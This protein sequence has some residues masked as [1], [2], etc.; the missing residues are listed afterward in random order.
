[1]TIFEGLLI[2]NLGVSLYLA[3]KIGG[4]ETDIEI[5]YQGIAQVIGDEEKS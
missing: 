4:I 5:L 1:M 2:L 3:Y